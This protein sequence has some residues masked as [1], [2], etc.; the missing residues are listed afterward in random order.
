LSGRRPTSRQGLRGRRGEGEAGHP[1][2]A[3][4]EVSAIL[5]KQEILLRQDGLR[6][7]DLQPEDRGGD[8]Q[9]EVLRQNRRRTLQRNV[10]RNSEQSNGVSKN[11]YHFKS[12]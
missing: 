11:K 6:S 1:P 5:E 3:G 7:E 12:P 9:D 10:R 4:R 8:R 2:E